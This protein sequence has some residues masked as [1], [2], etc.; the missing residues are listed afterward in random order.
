MYD[1]VFGATFALL[2]RVM[3][4]PQ[5]RALLLAIGLQESKFVHRTQIGGP[6]RGFWQFERGGGTA[7]V[8]QHTKTSDLAKQVL[9]ELRYPNVHSARDTHYLLHDND[10]LAC[11][12]ARLLLWTVPGA[13]PSR[14]NS[15]DGWRQYL[16]G[17]RP[18][19]P[20]P[21]TWDLYYT[22]AWDR[23]ELAWPDVAGDRQWGE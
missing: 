7:G 14:F 6:A 11:C 3:D 12:F 23:L 13:L 22:E 5:A 10:L 17:W 2:P 1:H 8:L 19:D 21:K 4:S 18:G 16:E 20:H 9:R 15:L